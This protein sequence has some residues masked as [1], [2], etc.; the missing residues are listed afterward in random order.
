[1]GALS[2]QA[3]NHDHTVGDKGDI[4]SQRGGKSGQR[5][6]CSPLLSIF[7]QRSIVKIYLL[8]IASHSISYILGVDYTY[9]HEPK[10]FKWCFPCSRFEFD[11]LTE[12]YFLVNSDP[13]CLDSLT[14][15]AFSFTLFFFQR[16]KEAWL[17]NPLRF[18]KLWRRIPPL[19]RRRP[20]RSWRY[21]PHREQHRAVEHRAHSWRQQQREGRRGI[22]RWL[23]EPNPDHERVH[24]RHGS[25]EPELQSQWEAGV[26]IEHCR[27]KSSHEQ[28][29]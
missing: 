8:K 20:Q 19:A 15:S 16:S 1:M 12:S 21:S 27:R 3:S 26:H 24:S 23:P 29:Q 13:V 9:E 22:W 10:Y 17:R 4:E 28:H 2:C 14:N 6:I 7:T 18:F 25:H 5:R 11:S